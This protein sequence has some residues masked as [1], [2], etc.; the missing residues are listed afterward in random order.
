M[1]LYKTLK[2][3]SIKPFKIMSLTQH[4]TYI[5]VLQCVEKK[6]TV[7]FSY[8]SIPKWY[9]ICRQWCKFIFIYV[10]IYWILMAELMVTFIFHVKLLHS[11]FKIHA[12]VWMM[13]YF[14]RTRI[15]FFFYFLLNVLEIKNKLSFIVPKFQRLS[16][17]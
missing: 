11:N 3:Q 2:T 9:S 7:F 5:N 1:I 17:R 14:N 15:Q 10:Y 12:L 16:S 4:S 13:H 8:F 6:Y